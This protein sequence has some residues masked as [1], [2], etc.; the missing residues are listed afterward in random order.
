M[1]VRKMGGQ[2][3]DMLHYGAA[4]ALIGALL[5]MFATIITHRALL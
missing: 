2:R 1:K 3:K 5:G 4:Y